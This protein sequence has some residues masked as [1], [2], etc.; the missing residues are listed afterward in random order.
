MYIIHAYRLV[1]FLNVVI[2]QL[3]SILNY[4]E[5][6]FATLH[7]FKYTNTMFESAKFSRNLFTAYINHLN[8]LS[9]CS[10]VFVTCM[11]QFVNITF[12]YLFISYLLKYIF[13][14]S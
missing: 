11:L 12:D 4:K 2:S 3:L 7:R 13:L 10:S 9:T 8:Q 6:V 5:Y 14:F 1:R